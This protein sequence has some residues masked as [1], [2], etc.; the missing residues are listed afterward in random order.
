MK[1]VVFTAMVTT[2]SFTLAPIALC[3]DYRTEITGSYSEF[4]YDFYSGDNYSTNVN[5]KR[6]RL[7]IPT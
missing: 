4:D 3:E 2:S 7:I 5:W 6:K 1:L